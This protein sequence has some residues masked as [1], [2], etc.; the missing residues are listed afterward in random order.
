MLPAS[1][2]DAGLANGA[3]QRV[4]PPVKPTPKAPESP[5]APLPLQQTETAP[6]AETLGLPIYPAAQFIASYDAGRGQRYYL[7][8]TSVSFADIVAYYKSVFRV[9]GEVIFDEPPVH[10]FDVGKFREDAM[11][12]PPGVTISDYTWGGSQGYVNPK[13][14]AQ[15]PRFPTIIQIVPLPPGSPETIRQWPSRPHS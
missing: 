2:L 13:P 9:K 12:F 7:F 10:A 1:G 6:T 5:P 3:A 15:P 4:A 14:G 8:G 11:A